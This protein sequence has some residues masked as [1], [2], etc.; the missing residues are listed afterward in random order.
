MMD[1]QPVFQ[2]GESVM[3]TKWLNLLQVKKMSK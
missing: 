2:A 3:V 1:S